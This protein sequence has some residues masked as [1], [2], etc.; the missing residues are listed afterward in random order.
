MKAIFIGANN[1]ETMRM[2]NAI[3]LRDPSFQAVGFL[4]NDPEKIGG[5]FYGLPIFGGTSDVDSSLLDSC[6]FVNLITRNTSI[7]KQTTDEVLSQGARLFNFI[8]P[9]INLEYTDLGEGLYIQDQ[10]I[11]QAGVSI[12]T[13]SSVHIGAMIGHESQIGS[14]CFVAHGC[15]LSGFTRLEEGV[16][17]GA[18][19]TTVPRITIGKWSII[20]AG[21][22]V[23]KDIPPYSV[24]VG[25]PARVIKRTN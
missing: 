4:D 1:P 10:V 7:R 12:G 21:S 13:N 17:F 18:G 25:N 14:S 6:L 15:N 19:V 5:D 23:T 11:V 22:V 3:K 16:F 9:T 8:H 24:A 20:G 2:I